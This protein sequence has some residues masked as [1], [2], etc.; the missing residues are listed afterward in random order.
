MMLHLR[1]PVNL[2]S[3]LTMI[4]MVCHSYS[5]VA[6]ALSTR[7]CFVPQ[8]VLSPSSAL[9]T[10]GSSVGLFLDCVQRSHRQIYTRES[11]ELF[12]SFHYMQSKS[13][14][15][16]L[17]LLQSISGR[18]ADGGKD[19]EKNLLHQTRR[20]ISKLLTYLSAKGSKMSTHINSSIRDKLVKSQRNLPPLV[21]LF[22]VLVCYVIHLSVFTQQSLVFPVQLIPNDRGKLNRQFLTL[23]LLYHRISVL[24]RVSLI[25]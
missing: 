20:K 17:P 23:C 10:R 5:L 14:G 7:P 19:D 21:Q 12:N 6:H 4:Y 11:I 9:L 2:P 24:A 15:R 18:C 16:C 25:F 22:I 1:S 3:I 8:K 13:N